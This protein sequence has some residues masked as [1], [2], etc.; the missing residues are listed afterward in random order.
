M[1]HCVNCGVEVEELYTRYCPNVLKLL[2]C[3]KCDHLADKYIEYDPVIILVDLI[4]LEKRSYRHLLYNC[5]LKSWWK[6]VIIIWLVESFRDL[7]LCKS[8]ETDT[9]NLRTFQHYF[10]GQCNLYLILFKTAFCLTAFVLTV[11]LYT[12]IK[13]YFYSKDKNKNNVLQLLKAI[14]VGG[15]GKLLGLLEITWGHIFSAPHYLLILGYTL[16]CWLTAYSVVSNSGKLESLIIL[17]L[18]ILVYSCASSFLS[19]MF[20]SLELI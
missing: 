13:W 12:T 19:T 9:D 6:L 11:I 14:V 15:C 8:N 17:G 20:E 3:D 1:Y 10:N 18:G 7:S 2:K 5:D 16:L 4:L